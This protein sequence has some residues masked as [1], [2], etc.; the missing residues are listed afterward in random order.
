MECTKEL[1]LHWWHYYGK[2]I[3]T[4]AELEK[5]SEIIDEYGVDKVLNAA[6]ASY[7]WE[8]GSPSTILLAI[9]SNCIAELFESL[10]DISKMTDTA[11][12]FFSDQKETFLKILSSSYNKPPQSEPGKI[13]LTLI[14]VPKETHNKKKSNRK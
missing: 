4:F 11:Q 3:Y 5:F 14:S 10:P 12:A 2:Q 7:L 8:D 13:T 9:R 1:L 6:L